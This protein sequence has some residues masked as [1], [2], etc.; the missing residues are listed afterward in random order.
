MRRQTVNI[1][2]VD[3]EVTYPARLVS[4]KTE[5]GVLVFFDTDRRS[6]ADKVNSITFSLDPN[7]NVIT[8]EY[9]TAEGEI[10]HTS[11]MVEIT[12]VV[13]LQVPEH[14]SQDQQQAN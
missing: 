9:E 12:E 8:H 6:L 3:Q 11:W 1:G 2:G 14:E 5:K 13:G 7:R 10:Y 4:S